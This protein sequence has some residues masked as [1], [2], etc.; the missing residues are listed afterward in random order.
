MALA[1]ARI[2]ALDERPIALPPKE[3]IMKWKPRSD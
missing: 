3:T 2:M 1:R